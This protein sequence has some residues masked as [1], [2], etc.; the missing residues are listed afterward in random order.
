[1]DALELQV[2]EG[3]NDG[4]M[5]PRSAADPHELA[6]ALGHEDGRG[7]IEVGP[8]NLYLHLTVATARPWVLRLGKRQLVSAA[9]QALGKGLARIDGL[10]KEGEGSEPTLGLADVVLGGVDGSAIEDECR[11]SKGKNA[12]SIVFEL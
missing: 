6:H 11:V 12:P 3:R 7:G 5:A 9:Y 10:A 2:E 8:G 1:M 4:R